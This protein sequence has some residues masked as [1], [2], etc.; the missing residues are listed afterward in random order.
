MVLGEMGIL[1]PI[2]HHHDMHETHVWEACLRL[3]PS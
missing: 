1:K 3:V 2:E